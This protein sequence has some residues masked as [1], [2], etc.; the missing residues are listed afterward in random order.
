M[1]SDDGLGWAWQCN[2]FGHY[3]LVRP[4]YFCRVTDLTPV[5]RGIQCRAL[6]A[7]LVASET[8]PGRVLWMSSHAAHASAYDTDDWQLVDSSTPYEG[9][10]FQMNLISAELSRRA[11]PSAAIRHF[12]V[13]PGVVNSSIDAALIGEFLSKIKVIVFYLVRVVVPSFSFCT[14]ASRVQY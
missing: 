1:I 5:V 4:P 11:G 2:V 10:K 6:E 3:I 13:H 8:G 7:K 12:T 14:N 9:T